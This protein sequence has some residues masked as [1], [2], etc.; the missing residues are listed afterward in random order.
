MKNALLITAS[1]IVVL[2]AF[3]IVFAGSKIK[4]AEQQS[5]L[6]DAGLVRAIAIDM[7]GKGELSANKIL[8]GSDAILVLNLQLA[9]PR[10]LQMI[11]KEAGG[12]GQANPSRTIYVF[13]DLFSLAQFDTDNNNV[14]DGQD[15]LYP[16]LTLIMF[17]DGKISRQI[18]AYNAGIRAIMLNPEYLILEER[19][20]DSRF[21]E[22]AATVVMSD[23]SVRVVKIVGID[24]NAFNQPLPPVTN[25]QPGAPGS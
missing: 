19:Q 23:S 7:D 20:D 24:V 15:P 2:V 4:P 11:Q 16:A 14:I 8:N 5:K 1:V 10:V 17:L 13:N 12:Q 21:K 3:Y 9:P 25:L 6:D 22:I 18:S